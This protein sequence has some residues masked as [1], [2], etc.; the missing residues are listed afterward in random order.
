MMRLL[1]YDCSRLA[2]SATFFF[3]CLA[4]VAA[5]VV[6]ALICPGY[7]C[8]MALSQAYLMMIPIAGI[9]T[10]FFTVQEFRYG[11]LRSKVTSGFKRNRIL[12]SW[13]VSLAIISLLLLAVYGVTVLIVHLLQGSNVLGNATVGSVLV[14]IV[15]VYVLMLGYVY[16]SL[17]VAF[18]SREYESIIIVLFTFFALAELG[19]LFERYWAGSPV[20]LRWIHLVP[21][22]HL[23]DSIIRIPESITVTLVGGGIAV[24]LVGMFMRALMRRRNLE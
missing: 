23:R 19:L 9:V 2:R 18:L 7:Q 3:A 24:C 11:I 20:L 5:G 1:R 4:T 12:C 22:S 14:N 15:M 17:L 13:M 6:G 21:T 8:V 10:V 16:L